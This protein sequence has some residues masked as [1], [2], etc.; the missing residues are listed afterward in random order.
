MHGL[1]APAL[2]YE[3]GGEPVQQVRVGWWLPLA[4]EIVG[5]AYNSATEMALPDPIYHH[6]GQERVRW[7][8]QPRGERLSPLPA[9]QIR[10]MLKGDRHV[11]RDNLSGRL[12]VAAI[13]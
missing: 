5:R 11:G 6:A 12:P 9:F 8:S 4:A 13:G 1:D 2:L 3:F 10:R 7:V